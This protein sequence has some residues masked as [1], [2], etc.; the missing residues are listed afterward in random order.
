MSKSRRRRQ[1]GHM[2]DLVRRC[3]VGKPETPGGIEHDFLREWK[4]LNPDPPAYPLGESGSSEER[5]SITPACV[6]GP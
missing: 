4:R 3:K 1:L 6:R 2:R 5:S